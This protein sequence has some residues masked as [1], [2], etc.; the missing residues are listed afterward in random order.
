[1]A[2]LPAGAAASC[3]CEICRMGSLPQV[4]AGSSLAPSAWRGEMGPEPSGSQWPQLPPLRAASF[5][6][7]DGAAD[8]ADDTAADEAADGAC[9]G[10]AD[11]RSTVC[12]R[13]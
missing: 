7:C 13:S 5:G 9:D 6:S 4:S 12:L 8:R 2:Q 1:M 11:S 10:V 3:T